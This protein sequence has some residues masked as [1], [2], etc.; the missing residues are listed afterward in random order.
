MLT[1]RQI[2]RRLDRCDGDPEKLT[3]EVEA[4]KRETGADKRR[5]N[6]K[7]TPTARE[8]RNEER[9]ANLEAA[10]ALVKERAGDTCEVCGRSDLRLE[11]DHLASGGLR[12]HR[13]SPET[14]LLVCCD[15]HRSKHRSD[16]AT[17]R[18]YVDACIRLGMK[19]G[20]VEMQRRLAKVTPSV[21]VQIIVREP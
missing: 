8:K 3:A 10:V 12:R 17:L 6:A 16:P 4:M 7:R 1:A 14:L 18:A 2:L 9:K 15:D 5:R 19:A 20:L 13:E 21:P 11:V